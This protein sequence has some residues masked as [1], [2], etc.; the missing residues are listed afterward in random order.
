MGSPQ[1][2]EWQHLDKRKYFLLGPTFNF[3]TL[4][5]L[6][7][8][9]LIKIRLQAQVGTSLYTGTFDAFGKVIRQEG[10]RALYKGIGPNTLTILAN[11]LYVANYEWSKAAAT[12][13]CENEAVRNLGAGIS[14]ACPSRC[15]I[16]TSHGGRTTQYTI[17]VGRPDETA[18]QT[19][20]CTRGLE[21]FLQG[22]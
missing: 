11:Q 20:L 2:I 18:D 17:Y 3:G 9:K 10:F 21:R 19:N 15:A 1:V 14:S 7:P 22:I 16:T 8:T 6:Y 4:L 12:P 5:L 13:Y